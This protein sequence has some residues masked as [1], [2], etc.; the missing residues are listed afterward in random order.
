MARRPQ[1]RAR[2]NFASALQAAGRNDEM[3]EQLALA[4]ADYPEARYDLG[5]QLVARGGDAERGLRELET[6]VREFPTH[7]S[8]AAARDLITR[9]RR[10]LA[11]QATGAEAEAREALA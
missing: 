11:M 7:P 1:G 8:A 2:L 3:L 6:F 5:A 10:Q 4:V 9:V